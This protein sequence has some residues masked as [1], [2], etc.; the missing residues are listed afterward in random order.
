ME[1]K[2]YQLE[3]HLQKNDLAACYLVS[4]DDPLLVDETCLLLRTAARKAGFLER[5]SFQAENENVWAEALTAASNFSLFSDRT[6]IEVRCKSTHLK[7]KALLSYLENPTPDCLLVISCEKIPATQ[8]KTKWMSQLLDLCG[9][10]QLWDIK[11]N[12][13]PRWLQQRASRERLDIEPAAMKVLLDNTEG[14]LLAAVQELEKLKLLHGE[15]KINEARMIAAISNSAR[16]N[17]FQLCD[18]MLQGKYLQTIRSF[19][20]LKNE[21]TA[22]PVILWAIT[23]ELRTLINVREGLNQKQHFETLMK[24]NGI[25]KERIPGYKLAL[26]RLSSREIYLQLKTLQSVDACIKGLGKQDPWLLCE[27]F[28]LTMC[29]VKTPA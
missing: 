14:N 24:K 26:N 12:E 18:D 10:I 27:Q 21:G 15:G 3:S 5:Q 8:K 4:G 7:E 25:W 20:G 16:Y 6:L 28:L 19:R 17:I 1:I 22:L 13:F 23:R 11:A 29:G 9:H 2:S